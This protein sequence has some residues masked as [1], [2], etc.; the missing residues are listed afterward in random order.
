MIEIGYPIVK[1]SMIWPAVLEVPDDLCL[2][3]GSEPL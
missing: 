3:L 2:M 1:S